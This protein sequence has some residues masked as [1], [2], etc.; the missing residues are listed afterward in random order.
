MY[1]ALGTKKIFALLV[2]LVLI[3][4]FSKYVIRHSGGFYVC[5]ANAAFG[6][7]IPEPLFWILWIGIIIFFIIALY[8]QYFTHN[9]LYLIL[10]LAGAASNV[11]D[12]LYFSCVTDFIELKF[13][14][15]FNL[16]DAFITIG[17]I[18]IILEIL[19][20]KYKK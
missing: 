2:F 10:I 5:N 16:A 3:D 12:R 15:M 1:K 17:G 9:N 8:K 7:K 19:K 6:L 11:I 18:M 13:W 14:P 4:Q 20:M